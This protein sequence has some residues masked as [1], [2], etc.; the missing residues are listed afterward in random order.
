MV[1]FRIRMFECRMSQDDKILGCII[2][3]DRWEPFR[4]L[5]PVVTPTGVFLAVPSR[6]ENLLYGTVRVWYAPYD[7]SE[8]SN[9]K[10]TSQFLLSK[11]FAALEWKHIH[12]E[13]VSRQIRFHREIR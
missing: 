9:K 13:T 8:C 5:T 3:I 11:I 6:T 12:E 2:E 4:T 1:E 10:F 7:T